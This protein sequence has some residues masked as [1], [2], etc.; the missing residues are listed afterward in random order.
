MPCFPGP[1]AEESGRW[2]DPARC[3]RVTAEAVPLARATWMTS[4]S[5]LTGASCLEQARVA[6]VRTSSEAVDDIP[7]LHMEQG[8]GSREQGRQLDTQPLSPCTALPLPCP[9][10][11]PTPDLLQAPSPSFPQRA[12]AGAQR[13]MNL[14][15]AR[16]SLRPAP[17]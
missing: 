4:L 10:S 9:A 6:L 2:Q 14:T 16:L 3:H 13:G 17:P 15:H 8:A 12:L 1:G 11:R 7:H 5:L